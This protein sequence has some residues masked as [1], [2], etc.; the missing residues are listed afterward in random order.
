LSNAD[1]LRAVKTKREEEASAL[2]NA[3]RPGAEKKV[4]EEEECFQ[5]SAELEE[6]EEEPSSGGWDRT[7]GMEEEEEV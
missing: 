2:L 1:E 5:D 3:L 6:L 4:K 7:G